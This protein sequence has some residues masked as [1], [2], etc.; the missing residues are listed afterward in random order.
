MAGC[1]RR[2]LGAVVL[3]SLVEEPR[4]AEADLLASFHAYS[5]HA[6]AGLGPFG[7]WAIYLAL[8]AA[9]KDGRGKKLSPRRVLGWLEERCGS[10]SRETLLN[11]HVHDVVTDY[12]H[13]FHPRAAGLA[14]KIVPL[15]LHSKASYA[16]H[17][18]T[19]MET[20]TL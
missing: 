6:E 5:R 16:E 4:E 9:L 19:H 13:Q 2:E 10:I 17:P 7:D 12:W 18:P 11:V 8:L 15:L 3:G 20:S 14:A 1:V